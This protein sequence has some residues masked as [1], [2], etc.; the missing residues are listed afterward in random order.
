M[1]SSGADL[2]TGQPGTNE[3]SN[4]LTPQP[5]SFSALIAAARQK[6]TSSHDSQKLKAVSE[7]TGLLQSEE[8]PE[9]EVPADGYNDA[10]APVPYDTSYT[11][12][13]ADGAGY[14]GSQDYASNH[15]A[16]TAPKHM[17]AW[18]ASSPSTYTQPPVKPTLAPPPP[19]VKPSA[20]PP[21]PPPTAAATQQV[22]QNTVASSADTQ[23]AGDVASLS[24]RLAAVFAGGAMAS[25]STDLQADESSAAAQSNASAQD[26]GNSQN[27]W[28][29]PAATATVG[30][31]A[32][33]DV[34]AAAPAASEGNLKRSLPNHSP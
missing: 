28:A 24:A 10:Q 1:D 32:T 19:P 15:A 13:S 11:T 9:A 31:A 20:A 17:D 27:T 26:T 7:Q 30:E 33:A 18:Q 4:G 16:D 29:P 6:R 22:H 3:D 8:E 34:D 2:G 25:Q 14:A 5:S 12:S 21:P 23:P